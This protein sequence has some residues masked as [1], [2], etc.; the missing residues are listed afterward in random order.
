MEKMIFY[1]SVNQANEN[2]IEIETNWDEERRSRIYN[3]IY[4][5]EKV[6]EEKGKGYDYL[7]NTVEDNNKRNEAL[8]RYK[9]TIDEL[10]RMLNEASKYIP[11]KPIKE[12][13]EIITNYKLMQG[14]TPKLVLLGKD[15]KKPVN[16]WSQVLST[17]LDRMAQIYEGEFEKVLEAGN[18]RGRKRLYFS[19]DESILYSP[20]RIAGSEYYAE[21]NNSADILIKICCKLL[22]DLNFEGEFGVE[23]K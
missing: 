22:S 16:T 3:C 19:K 8:A 4:E 11:N 6:Y 14:T 17:V 20:K 12:A 7:K 21:S 18:I 10:N 2:L 1:S 15:F 5:L 13:R 23:I 9:Q